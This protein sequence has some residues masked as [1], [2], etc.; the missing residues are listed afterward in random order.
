MKSSFLKSGI[1]MMAIGMF[2][3]SCSEEEIINGNNNGSQNNANKPAVAVVFEYKV[4]ES[5]DFLEYC[6]IALE[7]NDGSDAKT[8]AITATEWKKTLTAALPCKLTFNKTVTLKADK[9]MQEIEKVAY[10]L[11]SYNLTYYLIDADGAI[12]SKISHLSH[13]GE[14]TAA[15][16]K[17]APSVAQGRFNTSKSY[18]FDAKGTLQ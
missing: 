9:D 11:N 15:S 13:N 4:L 12:A 5:A 18:E 14:A 17:I 10:H 8:E 1:L 16:S 3:S 6:D 7:Y 2:F